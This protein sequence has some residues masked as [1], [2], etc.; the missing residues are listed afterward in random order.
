MEEQ[1]KREP[2]TYEEAKD[3]FIEF[4]RGEHHFPNKIKDYGSGWSMNHN[5]DLATVDWNDLT[6]L[7]L[8]AHDRC[9]RVSVM[10]GAPRCVKIVVHKRHMREGSIEK[11]HP[12]IEAALEEWR[13]THP[14]QVEETTKRTMNVDFNNLRRK[15]L[16]SYIHITEIINKHIDNSNM[17]AINA[18]EIERE[19]DNLRM[20]LVCIAFT[21][22]EG[23]E[24]F[25]DLDAEFPDEIISLTT[26]E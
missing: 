23:N 16:K 6:R 24:N 4:Y 20:A 7:V 17:I 3:F 10:Q 19:W 12:T 1:I 22:E 25:K 5:H 14:L 26:N 2:L 8:M 9:Y 15:A 13:K 11:K 18:E 21:S